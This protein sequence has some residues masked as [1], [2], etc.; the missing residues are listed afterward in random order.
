LPEDAAREIF[1]DIIFQPGPSPTYEDVM[2]DI[3]G[4]G[5][6]PGFIIPESLRELL[7]AQRRQTEAL[8][9]E[10]LGTS[11][12]ASRAASD[13]GDAMDALLD[14]IAIAEG[15][16]ARV[17]YGVTDFAD[18]GN[19]FRLARNQALFDQLVR[20]R[21]LV[22]GTDEYYRAAAEVTVLHYWETFREL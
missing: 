8:L 22:E 20:E 19:R 2:R 7:D 9:N 21:G 1:P 3:G 13:F 16:T 17:P 11:E 18:M 4:Q 14:A 5:E 15:S 10:V 12:Q 6:V